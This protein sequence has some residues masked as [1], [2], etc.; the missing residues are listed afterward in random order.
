M[1]LYRIEIDAPDDVAA[2]GPLLML[3]YRI[4]IRERIPQPAEGVGY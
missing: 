3:L 4:E 2:G 1:L